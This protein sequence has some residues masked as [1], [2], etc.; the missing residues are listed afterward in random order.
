MNI[1]WET[2]S[3]AEYVSINLMRDNATALQISSSTEN[4]GSFK[5]RIPSNLKSDS[6]YTL[7]I[8]ATD[9]SIHAYSEIFTIKAINGISGYSLPLLIAGIILIGLC[10]FLLNHEKILSYGR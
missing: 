7:L 6:N 5:W 4:T 8:N 9:N 3:S 2:D 10:I 1:T